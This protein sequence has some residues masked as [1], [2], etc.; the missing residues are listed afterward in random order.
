MKNCLQ[1]IR[2]HVSKVKSM[3]FNMTRPSYLFQ[4]KKVEDDLTDFRALTM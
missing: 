3:L 2:F 1:F 4:N